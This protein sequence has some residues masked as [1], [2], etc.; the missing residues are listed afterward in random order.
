MSPPP[1][2]WSPGPQCSAL[3]FTP[4]LYA[5]LL[6]CFPQGQE[7]VKAATDSDSLEMGRGRDMAD[8]FE[9]VQGVPAVAEPGRNLLQPESGFVSPRGVC[10]RW[11][12]PWQGKGTGAAGKVWTNDLHL[13]I[14]CW[15]QLSCPPLVLDIAATACTASGAH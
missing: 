8:T 10:L 15:Q 2:L 14:A 12:V 1:L 11:W 5:A 4:P 13:L 3:V 6:H 9:N 7:G